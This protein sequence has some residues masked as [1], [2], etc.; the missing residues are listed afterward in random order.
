[1]KQIWDKLDRKQKNDLII[2]LVLV[3][4]CLLYFGF[5]SR[6]TDLRETRNVVIRVGDEEVYNGPLSVSDKELRISG[7][8]GGSNVFVME[9]DEQGNAGLRCIEADCPDLI[10]VHTG[11]VTLPDEPI[12]CLP[13][14]VTARITE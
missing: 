12:V 8:H 11:L 7:I 2:L 9:K 10:C 4:G 14:R 3:I 13:H 1:M 5:H 6:G